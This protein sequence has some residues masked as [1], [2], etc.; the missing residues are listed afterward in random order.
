MCETLVA[1]CGSQDA[2]VLVAINDSP[3]V[4]A[5]IETNQRCLLKN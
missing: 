2:I 3:I 5:E 1:E 4:E